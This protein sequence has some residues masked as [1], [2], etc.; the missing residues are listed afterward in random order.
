MSA[1]V[2]AINT[3]IT[4]YVR[5]AMEW[6]QV[7]KEPAPSLPRYP[8]TSA[9]T[10]RDTMSN[11]SVFTLLDTLRHE[12]RLSH[13]DLTR[14]QSHLRTTKDLVLDGNVTIHCRNPERLIEVTY[15]VFNT[16]ELLENILSFLTPFA[17]LW[18]RSV[19][20]EFC[21]VIDSAPQIRQKMFRQDALDQPVIPVPYRIRGLHC[22]LLQAYGVKNVC[23]EIDKISYKRYYEQ[24]LRNSRILRS[25]LLTQP[26]PT[27]III[28]RDCYC[29]R[30]NGHSVFRSEED[31]TFGDLFRAIDKFGIRCPFCGTFLRLRIYTRGHRSIRA[32]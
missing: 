12:G 8:Q 16:V 20:K 31:L 27:E 32:S 10:H 29:S 6:P 13:H 26:S 14:I 25:L 11:T 15:K 2:G 23:L 24:Y 17:Q 19:S 21:H 28:R 7:S 18:A 30:T 1:S 5:C 3:G 4:H 9:I 22:K